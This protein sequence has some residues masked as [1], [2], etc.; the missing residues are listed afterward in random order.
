MIKHIVMFKLKD[1]NKENIEKIVDAL[2][3]LEGNIDILR[4]AEIGINF[5]ESERNYDIVLTT[6]FDDRNALNA[7][8][9]HPNHLPVVETVRSLC[10]GS[11]V[12]DYET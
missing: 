7:Y 10:S 3:T 1:R 2:K 9:P 4:S 11:V 12:V 6:E 8:G 5:T